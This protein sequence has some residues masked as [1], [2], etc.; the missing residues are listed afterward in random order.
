LRSFSSQPKI[1]VDPV[2]NK[3]SEIAKDAKHEDHVDFNDLISNTKSTIIKA[4]PQFGLTCLAL[5]LTRE[6]WR[7]QKSLWL[8]LDSKSMKPHSH[9][10][11]KAIKKELKAIGFTHEDVKC[12]ILDSWTSNEES[13]F[14]L[15]KKVCTLFVGNP[16]IVMQT[17]ENTQFMQI[18][19]WKEIDREFEVLFLWALPRGHVRKV[20]TAYNE[21]RPIGEN[22]AVITKVVSDLEVLNL[23]RTPLN[24][25]TLLKVSEID[26]DESPVNRTEMIKRVLFLLFNVDDIPTY[27]VRPD[28]KDCEYVLGYLCETMIRNN[29]FSFTRE[30]FL[31]VL[32]DFL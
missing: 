18:S 22:D 7:R 26:F 10:I 30:S 4:P 21:K 9:S 5:H 27:K 8:Y 2:L 28:L 29:D 20:V 17:I 6:A 16:V 25:L 23:H 24:C 19:D 12:V 15:L 32:Q 11:E 3:N 31:G 13:S 14:R 1:W